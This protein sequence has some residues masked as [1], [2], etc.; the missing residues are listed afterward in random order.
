MFADLHCHAHMRSYFCLRQKRKK[1]EKKGMFN[2]WTVVASN[3]SRLKHAD[4]AIGYAQSDLVA[5]WNGGGRLIF[6]SLYPIEKGFFFTPKKVK[7]GKFKALRKMLHL[8]THHKAPLRTLMQHLT[9]RIP[10]SMIKFVTSDE[11]DY[12][13]FLQEEYDYITSKSGIKCEN[14][15]YT[16][17]IARKLLENNKKRRKKYP[18]YYHAEGTYQIPK[19]R[20][21]A[22]EIAQKSDEIILMALSIEGAH[23]F[24]AETESEKTVLERVDLIKKWEYPLFFITFSHHFDNGLCGHA[25]SLP[26]I[27]SLVLDQTEFMNEGFTELGWK[28]IRKLL[29]IDANNNPAPQEGHRVLIDLKHASAKARKEFYDQIINPCLKKGD[30]IPLIASHC[31]Y[32][33]V[34]TLDELIANA[35]NEV[36]AVRASSEYG[37]FY[38]WNINLCDE[39]IIMI[40]KTGGL[41]GLSFDKRMLGMSPKKKEEKKEQLN[42]IKSMWNNVKAVMS[43]IY[44]EAAVLP[45][46]ERRKAWDILAIGTDFDGYIDPISDYKTA[47]ELK[48]F[49]KDLL[50]VI[51]EEAAKKHPLPCVADFDEDFT[52]EMV[53]NKIC[54]DNALAFTLKHY[55]V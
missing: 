33:G 14:E 45:I 40:Y 39:D 41:F 11:Y 42:S 52:P 46:T 34:K 10:A 26:D 8:A 4:R 19:N 27:A 20:A 28:V 18:N 29:S 22:A 2:P 31:A 17:G 51:K 32:A 1:M 7:E 37:M 3:M 16:L 38:N 9:M 54:Y 23:V 49:K 36:E 6:N 15:V 13:S 43:I 44:K 35:K 48:D 5:L 25:H 30:V 53:V 55:P 21:E 12:W 50:H 24:G 47:I